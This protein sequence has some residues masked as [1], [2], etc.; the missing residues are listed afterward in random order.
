MKKA[1]SILFLLIL[2]VSFVTEVQAQRRKVIYLQTYD[3]APYHF[4]FLLGVNFM[5]YQLGLKDN[6]QNLTL[7]KDYLPHPSAQNEL[8][9]VHGNAKFSES[10]VQSFNINRVESN[11]MTRN[12]GFSVGVIGDLRLSRYFNLRVIPTLSLSMKHV[13]YNLVLYNENGGILTDSQGNITGY[14][15]AVSKDFLATYLEFPTHIK[16][17]S[18]RYNNIGAY[19]IGGFNPKLY[20]ISGLKSTDSNGDPSFLIPKRFDIA[21]EVGTGFDIYNQWF[22]MGVEIKMSFG[23]FNLLKEDN[24]SQEFMYQAPL[25]SLKSKQLQLSFTFE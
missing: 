7:S 9:D 24:E 4:G 6:Y 2:S 1:L 13:Y 11:R 22:K 5:D 17:R 18:K 23:M 19:L 15:R 3:N 25:E 16:Y 8:A 20:L 10:N 21:L 14:Q 12:P